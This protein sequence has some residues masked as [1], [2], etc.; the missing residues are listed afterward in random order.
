MLQHRVHQTYSGAI[1]LG[2]AART[3]AG[4]TIQTVA[5]DGAQNLTITGNLDLNGA[6]TEVAV[7]S[8]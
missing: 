8:C 2:T 7:F 1:T 4:S 6:I 3:L 5:V